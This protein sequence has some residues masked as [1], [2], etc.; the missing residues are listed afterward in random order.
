MSGYSFMRL[1]VYSNENKKQVQ[2][3]LR[4]NWFEVEQNMCKTTVKTQILGDGDSVL[5]MTA[6]CRRRLLT[7][8]S[9]GLGTTDTRDVLWI[10]YAYLWDCRK[11]TRSPLVDNFRTEART[12]FLLG[13]GWVMCRPCDQIVGRNERCRNAVFVDNFQTETPMKFIFGGLVMTPDRFRRT[14]GAPENAMWSVWSP[15]FERMVIRSWNLAGC[16]WTPSQWEKH[17]GSAWKRQG[18]RSYHQFSHG[19]S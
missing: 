8:H 14:A 10:I 5:G 16:A 1:H 11:A 17:S 3:I 19:R 2:A 7:N 13:D 18:G 6:K 4:Q 15:T 9:L 12:K